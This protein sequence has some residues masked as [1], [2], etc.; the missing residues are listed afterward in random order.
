MN[1]IG[2]NNPRPCQ[3]ISKYVYEENDVVKQNNNRTK[4]IECV[5]CS[6]VIYVTLK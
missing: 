1:G 3:P 4:F 5:F 2:Y 6:A